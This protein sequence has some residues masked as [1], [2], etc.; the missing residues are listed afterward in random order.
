VNVGVS[1]LGQEGVLRAA[2]AGVRRNALE[3]RSLERRAVVVYGVIGLALSGL[4]V[5]LNVR[6]GL[7]GYDFRGSL[8]QAG[9][10]ILD[11]RSPYPAPSAS[12][13]LHVGNAFVYPPLSA[14]VSLPLALLPQT[15]AAAVWALVNAAALAGA[16]W[17]V[18]LR[19]YRCYV[20]CLGSYPVADSL[21]LGQLDGL[22]ALAVAAGWR[23][24][25]R[26]ALGGAAIGVAIALKLLAWPLFLWL[27]FTR[28]F[29]AALVCIG[30]TV[31][32]VFGAWVAIGFRGLA[33]YPHL[34]A[35]D[36]EAFQ[37]RSHSIVALALRVGLSEQASRTAA[38][39]AASALLAVAMRETR[40]RHGDE[41][42]A[43]AAAILAGIVASPVVHQHYWVVLLVPLAAAKPSAGWR[44]LLLLGFWL[45]PVE[46][47]HTWQVAYV[48]ILVGLLLLS[49]RERHAERGAVSRDSYYDGRETKR[50]NRP[51]VVA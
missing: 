11:G 32:L 15:P 39:L 9:K 8:W 38:F 20:L 18:G 29:R 51:S 42:F 33:A 10:A 2:R 24:R 31:S 35:A 23:F 22:L 37:N 48:L 7:F 6:G 13:L 12:E 30:T 46:P 36:A 26:A 14:L 47:M 25:N 45:S 1:S 16:L 49:M 50:R 28:R 19:D 4:T 27:L 5:F 17:L 3:W 41:L 21:I 44:W 43:F 34:L 40:A